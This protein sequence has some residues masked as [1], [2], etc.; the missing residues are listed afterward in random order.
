MKVLHIF[1]GLWMLV[2]LSC[3]GFLD[4]VD[5]DKFIPSTTDHYASVLLEEF[6][7]E[8]G[9]MPDVA[10][11]TDEIQEL[12]SSFASSSYRNSMLPIYTWQRD[13]E[14]TF[15]NEQVGNNTSWG[16]LYRNIAI[17]NYVI[18]QIDDATGTE[19]E[20]DYVKGEAYFI[21]AYC[22]FSL[23]NLY[24]EPY[25]SAAGAEVTMGVPLRTDIGVVPTYDRAMLSDNYRQIEEDLGEAIRLIGNSGLEKSIYHPTVAACRLLLSRVQLFQKKYDDVITTATGVMEV[26]G[27]KKLTAGSASQ[28]FITKSNPEVLYSFGGNSNSAGVFGTTIQRYGFETHR[29]LLGRFPENDLRKS[30]FFMPITDKSNYTGYFTWKMEAGYSSLA[31]INFRAAEAWLNRAEAYACRGRIGEAQAD[32]RALME[33]RYSTLEEVTIPSEQQAL[34]RF[35]RDERFKEFC[36]EEHFRWFDLRRMEEDE[37]P[38][39]VHI[40]SDVDESGKKVG[41]NTYRLLKNDPNYTLSVPEQEKANN[42]FIYDY[43]RFDKMPE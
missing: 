32:I 14:R 9:I 41:K 5:Q 28:P 18:E 25:R 19:A 6:N 33:N 20:R 7:K 26:T 12:E 24:A 40:C 35:I 36:F 39:I 10:F 2:C 8:P 13:I 42:P 43:E 29:E 27:L 34:I 3:S 38:E 21:R 37:R 31:W 22:Y 23:T 16:R 30:L 1:L 15:E 17:V 11:M 4:E